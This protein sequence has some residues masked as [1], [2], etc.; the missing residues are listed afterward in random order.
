[1]PSTGKKKT[2]GNIPLKSIVIKFL[3]TGDKMRRIKATMK[4][5]TH[6]NKIKMI[7]TLSNIIQLRK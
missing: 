4:K 3:K 2:G 1:M 6:Y 5:K 7:D